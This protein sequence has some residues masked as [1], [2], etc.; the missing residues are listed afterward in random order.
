M[1]SCGGRPVDAVSEPADESDRYAV[2]VGCARQTSN[3]LEACA[4]V[5]WDPF[6][7][8]DTRIG[9]VCTS[10]HARG[11]RGPGWL[12]TQVE[13]RWPLTLR[14]WLGVQPRAYP[15]GIGLSCHAYAILHRVDPT[16][17]WAQRCSRWLAW[18]RANPSPGYRTAWGYPFFWRSQIPIPALTPS[19]V[20]S[21]A[22]GWAF[23]EAYRTWGRVED[24][25]TAV[26]VAQTL[27]EA[28]RRLPAD[29]GFCFSYTPIDTMYVHNASLLTAA[30]LAD[31]CEIEHHPEWEDLARGACLYTLSHQEPDGSFRYFGP[32]QP[33]WPQ[34]MIDH[35]HTGFVLRCLKKLRR[36]LPERVPPSL[37]ACYRHYVTHFFGADHAPQL[38]IGRRHPMDVHAVAEAALVAADFVDQDGQA[39]ERGLAAIKTGERLLGLGDGSY[40]AARGARPTREPIAYVRWGA[41]WMLL[42]NAR[43]AQVL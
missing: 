18:L 23:L 12:F 42:A 15:K 11:V 2:R 22:C 40:C 19:G 21:T 31:V 4:H 8:K 13:Q 16:G 3:W 25:E 30:F 1:I 20:V 24:R 32:P 41:A 5:G 43:L 35:F 28:L 39:L 9:R 33:G 36:L 37:S 17:P 26:L 10:L 27:V 6:D 38:W 34:S 7:V 14:R 29:V